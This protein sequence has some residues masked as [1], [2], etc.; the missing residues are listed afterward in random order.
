MFQTFTTFF[1]V[2]RYSSDALLWPVGVLAGGVL[3]IFVG[4]QKRD[5]GIV[6]KAMSFLVLPVLMFIAVVML[7]SVLG[8][9]R[10]FTE[11]LRTEHCSVVQGAVTVLHQQPYSG[12]SSGD[13]IEVGG[14]RFDVNYFRYGVGYKQTISHGGCLT[15]GV[16]ARLHFLGD[17]ILRVEIQQPDTALGPTASGAGSSATAGDDS[18]RRG[19]AFGR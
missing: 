10:K 3:M 8:D 2:S 14:K 19:S 17:T 18:S 15:N 11:A 7:I 5:S 12:H 9:G 13:L 1:E 6:G 16:L 4:R